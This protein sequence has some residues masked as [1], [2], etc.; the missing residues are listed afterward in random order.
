MLCS[1][2]AQVVRLIVDVLTLRYTPD[3]DKD[4]ELLVLRH[5]IRILER[6]VEKPVGA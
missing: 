1:L 5:Q 4:L 6:R 2:I 3:A